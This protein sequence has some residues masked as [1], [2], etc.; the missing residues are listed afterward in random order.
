LFD[1]IRATDDNH[2]EATELIGKV[3]MTN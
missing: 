1:P 2:P 3:F